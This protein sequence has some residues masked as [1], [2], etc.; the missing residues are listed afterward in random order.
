MRKEES[1]FSETG[2]RLKTRNVKED[3]DKEEEDGGT[4]SFPEESFFWVEE[5]PREKKVRRR[6]R[7]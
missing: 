7:K 4:F 2:K 3:A 6:R 5:F 1:L